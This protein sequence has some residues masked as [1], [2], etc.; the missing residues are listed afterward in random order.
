MDTIL[1]WREVAGYY[2]PTPPQVDV[3]P[4][5]KSNT[6][7]HPCPNYRSPEFLNDPH[8]PWSVRRDYYIPECLV[9]GWKVLDET[10]TD[11][12]GADDPFF[13]SVELKHFE[14]IND[15]QIKFDELT[16]LLQSRQEL[17]YGLSWRNFELYMGAVFRHL[18]WET[19][20]TQPTTDGGAD[21]ILLK[22]GS[23]HSIVECKRNAKT[24][25]ISVHQVRALVGA[26][27][28][29]ETQRATL[30]TTSA[31]TKP[32]KDYARRRLNDGLEIDLI[33]AS[34]ILEALGVRN[35]VLP[36]L[37]KIDPS[38]LRAIRALNEKTVF[39]K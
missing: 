3:C 31:F 23:I 6:H 21:L 5:C 36:R 38:M 13:Q 34:E 1:L 39:G 9:C 26:A 27:L 17:L 4:Y 16:A 29:F 24:R 28:D 7:K 14:S 25:K 30:I 22:D 11:W 2:W 15:E 10:S 18:G 12:G 33:V 35:S 37:D 8:S 32:A 19:L 20:V